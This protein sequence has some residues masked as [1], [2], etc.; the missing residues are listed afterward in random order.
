MLQRRSRRQLRSM[1]RPA[2]RPPIQST[3]SVSCKAII[4]MYRRIDIRLYRKCWCARQ[5]AGVSRGI[6]GNR[7]CFPQDPPS[8]AM[9]TAR[10]FVRRYPLAPGN[11]SGSMPR[12]AEFALGFGGGGDGVQSD[13]GFLDGATISAAR[14]MGVGRTRR[15]TTPDR[16]PGQAA[17]TTTPGRGTSTARRAGGGAAR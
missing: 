14:G 13:L 4:H 7:P 2:H 8:S 9:L 12:S 1:Q 6:W 10:G 15:Q 3:R 11:G 16:S 5:A 17:R